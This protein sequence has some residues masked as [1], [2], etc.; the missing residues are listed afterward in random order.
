MLSVWFKNIHE[1]ISCQWVK[2][3]FVRKYETKICFS[4]TS[5]VCFFSKYLL[6]LLIDLGHDQNVRFV[7]CYIFLENCRW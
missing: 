3:D 2:L 6:N 4:I 1:E 7:L 5:K